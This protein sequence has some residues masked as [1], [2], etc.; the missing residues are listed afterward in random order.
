MVATNSLVCICA[1]LALAALSASPA[2][3][4]LPWWLWAAPGAAFALLSL[5]PSLRPTA[6]ESSA[7]GGAVWWAHMRPLHA[8]LW[9]AHAVVVR[10]PPGAS[11]AITRLAPLLLLADAA[12]GAGMLLRRDP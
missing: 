3:R 11:L 2:G 6:R 9:L 1:R 7:P 4:A 12:I 5:F 10:W 8:A